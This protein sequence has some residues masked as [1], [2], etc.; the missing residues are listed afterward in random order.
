MTERKEPREITAEEAKALSEANG[1]KVGAEPG[2]KTAAI[3]AL[4]ERFEANEARFTEHTPGPWSFDKYDWLIGPGHVPVTDYAGCGSHACDIENPYDKALILAAPE[5]LAA[6]KSALAKFC[7]I[8][9]PNDSV[10]EIADYLDSVITKA[11][12][13]EE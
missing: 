7:T 2:S 5:L 10:T 3:N 4:R 12:T 13:K 1:L 8:L 11:T 9:A 6:C